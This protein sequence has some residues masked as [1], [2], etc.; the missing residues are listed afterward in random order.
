MAKTVEALVTPALLVWARERS[1]FEIE[2][3]AT[4]LKID[5]DVLR[6]WES[7][8]DRPSIAKLREVA[9]LYKRPPAVFYLPRP[10][11]GFVPLRDLRKLPKTAQRPRSPELSVGD[12]NGSSGA[13][14]FPPP[15]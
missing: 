9:S 15:R 3:A 11:R 2:A 5:P 4:R 13:P 8:R 7:G 14:T 10:P 1:G 12:I 6:S